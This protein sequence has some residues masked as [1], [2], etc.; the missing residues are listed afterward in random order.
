MLAASVAAQ[1]GAS[2]AIN[3][4]AFLIPSLQDDRGLSLAAGR[5]RR[6]DA[7]RRGDGHPV[8]LGPG[9]STASAS[10]PCCWPAWAVRR[11]SAPSR[12]R[13]TD[14][15]PLGAT[16]FVVGMFAA[17]TGSA[18]GRIVVGWFPPRRRGLAMGI[19]QMAQP[20]GVADRRGDDRGR[21][22]AGRRVAPRCGSPSSRPRWPSS[23][24]CSS[25]STRRG[26]TATA[27]L[28]AN[29]YR[30]DSFL[31]RIHGVSVLLV[32]PQFLVWTYSLTWLVQE[33]ALVRRR[34]G[35]PGRRHPRARRPGPDRRRPALRRGR[36]ARAPAALGG[37]R[38]CRDDG[39]AGADR[40]ARRRGRAAGGR[41]DGHRGRQRAGV[42]ERGR[43]GRLLLVGSGTRPAEHGAVPH[44][45]RR[46]PGRRTRAS[47]TGATPRRTPSRRCARWSPARSSRARTRPA[48]SETGSSAVHR[49]DRD[50][51]SLV[52]GPTRR[53]REG[54]PC[55]A[56]P[57]ARLTELTR[58]P[59]SRRGRRPVRRSGARRDR[60]TLRRAR[61]PHRPGRGRTATRRPTSPRRRTRRPRPRAP[62]RSTSPTARTSTLAAWSTTAAQPQRPG[63]QERRLAQRHG[64]RRRDGRPDHARRRHSGRS[65]PRQPSARRAS[66]SCPACRSA[67]PTR[68]RRPTATTCSTPATGS[69]PRA[70]VAG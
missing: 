17:C 6:R 27:A 42:H 70:P 56:S 55:A 64:D 9:R 31:A 26:P 66:R 18:S 8:R 24:C 35:R 41:L 48:P 52:A 25:C 12:R 38:G 14:T 62:T 20:L 7:D 28:T 10:A 68:P 34:G 22:R 29:P 40:A 65:R 53:A 49:R 13:C 57:P 32:V 30:A 5:H 16:L 59:S 51:S 44:G 47:R 45:G 4:P 39:P 21:R 2:V 46:G 19:R 23:L 1:A 58:G 33:R 61:G 69:S 60:R 15:V 3:G 67:R 11:S 36:L 50:G 43:A 54:H 37:A 63:D